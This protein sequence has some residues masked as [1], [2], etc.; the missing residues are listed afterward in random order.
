[1]FQWEGLILNKI[2]YNLDKEYWANRYSEMPDSN[3][4]G[5]IDWDKN[6]YEAELNSWAERY[7]TILNTI[8][9][10]MTNVLDFGCGVGRWMSLLYQ[11]FS[12]YYGVDIVQST[13]DK[14]RLNETPFENINFELMTN[15]T[16]PQFNAKFDLIWTC[17]CLQHI[18][19]DKLLSNYI[20]QFNNLLNKDGFIICTENTSNNK[21]S[22]YL[23]FRSDNNYKMLFAEQSLMLEYSNT[24]QSSGEEHTIMFFKK[25]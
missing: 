8:P 14:A 5:H 9:F 21:D 17:V 12:N 19:D 22:N 10:K 3:V 1:M 2:D 11:Y 4:V 7:I 20:S 25:G 6:K 24:F 15:E 16:I 13:I 18:V 23:K